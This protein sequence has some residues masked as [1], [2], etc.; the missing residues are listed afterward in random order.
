MFEVLE[1]QAEPHLAERE[2]IVVIPTL[3]RRQPYAN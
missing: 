2:E 1:G 3:I